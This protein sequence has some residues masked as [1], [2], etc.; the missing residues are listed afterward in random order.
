[1][2]V[3][4][5]VILT[6]IEG[7]NNVNGVFIRGFYLSYLKPADIVIPSWNDLSQLEIDIFFYYYNLQGTNFYH[8]I[9][10]LIDLLIM[11]SKLFTF[12]N[13]TFRREI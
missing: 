12:H 8:N 6:C 1:M 9:I 4:Q 13:K 10:L 7:H 5:E 11:F 2:E 3:K